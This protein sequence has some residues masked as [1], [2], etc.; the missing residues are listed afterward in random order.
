MN[1]TP[2]RDAGRNALRQHAAAQHEARRTQLA[3]QLLDYDSC[4]TEQEKAAA[5]AK[6][7]NACRDVMHWATIADAAFAAVER[8]AA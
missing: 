8:G 3:A 1:I 6:H 2:N 4:A 7:E 5:W